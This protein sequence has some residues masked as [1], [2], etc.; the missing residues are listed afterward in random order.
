VTFLESFPGVLEIVAEE[1]DCKSNELLAGG[2]LPH[3]NLSE[4]RAIA[5]WI[6]YK[7]GTVSFPALGRMLGMGHPA[8]CARVKA[9]ARRRDQEPQ[10]AALSKVAKPPKK[11]RKPRAPSPPF[12]A[13][14]ALAA[15]DA[16][17]KLPP[18][19]PIKS[20]RVA[21]VGMLVRRFALP[22]DL[23]PTTNSTR[24][25]K[26]WMLAKMKENLRAVMLKQTRGTVRPTPLRGRPM[27]RC[28]RFSK[29]APDRYADWMKMAV[30]RLLVGEKRL[31]YLVD[32]DEM[33]VDIHA[34]W[35]PS[36]LKSKGFCVIE[37]W[38]GVTP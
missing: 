4:A 27:L 5:A 9:V 34:W 35:E 25:S 12:N 8:V 23:C 17:L 24:H 7:T 21:P 31:G 36:P 10:L 2:K 19:N 30:D 3:L 6:A 13:L 37:I 15:A 28:I 18:A 32:D 26:G 33:H 14:E 16:V 22:I 29:R 20:R 38:T 1:F 11:P